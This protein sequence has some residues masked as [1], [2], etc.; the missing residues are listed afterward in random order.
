M[1]IK[2]NFLEFSEKYILFWRNI[3]NF[4]K[5]ILEYPLICSTASND[6]SFVCSD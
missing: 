1:V 3:E 6:D 2:D 5:I 4:C